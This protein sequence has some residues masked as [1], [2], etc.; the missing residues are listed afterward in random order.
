VSG[1]STQKSWAIEEQSPRLFPNPAKV[2][3]GSESPTT[4]PRRPELSNDRLIIMEKIA[5]NSEGM[6]MAKSNGKRAMVL[7]CLGAIAL[8]LVLLVLG[9]LRHLASQ[10]DEIGASDFGE[11]MIHLN[12]GN[13]IYLK[14]EARGLN[15][16]VVAVSENPNVCE[17]AN[18]ETDLIFKYD[19]NPLN[20]SQSEDKLTIFW[21]WGEVNQPKHHLTNVAVKNVRPD[22]LSPEDRASM[23]VQRIDIPMEF[24]KIGDSCRKK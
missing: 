6:L 10:V 1:T 9:F 5:A 21:A 2:R 23:K 20:V 12:N 24:E 11:R 16:D 14:R 8:G 4:H 18:P 15:F 3:Q 7:Y 13:V 17:S 19:A 22:S